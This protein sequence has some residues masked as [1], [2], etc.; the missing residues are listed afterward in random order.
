MRWCSV[1]ATRQGALDEEA[2]HGF[3]NPKQTMRI[4]LLLLCGIHGVIHLMGLSRGPRLGMAWG[5]AALLFLVAALL[6]GLRREEWWW[7]AAPAIVLSQALVV[8]AWPEAKSGTIA[9]VVLAVAVVGGAAHA[10]FVR[11]IGGEIVALDAQPAGPAP[12]DPSTLPPLVVRWLTQS[13]ALAQPGI[14]RVSLQQTAGLRTTP[15][16]A[17]LPTTAEQHIAVDV[18]AFVWHAETAFFHVVPVTAR[19]RYQRGVGHMLVKAAS[20]VPVVD[21]HDDKIADGALVRFLGEIVWY[22]AAALRPYLTWR[23]IDAEHVEATL[24]A[25]GRSV[26]ATFEID[27]AGHVVAVR[28][29]RYLGG[30]ADAKLT[31]WV[32]RCTAWKRFG[33]VEVP[34]RGTVAWELPAGEFVYYEWELTSLVYDPPRHL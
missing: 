23:G 1:C 14:R 4:A 11:A 13:G 25:D 8:S 21:A 27:G 33:A 26:A 31:P 2:G 17:P 32:A 12:V 15:T 24:G 9:N 29:Q 10:R 3:G 20:L 7:L 18:P 30:G 22:P 5:G 6:V 34:V 16:S 19:D 28:A